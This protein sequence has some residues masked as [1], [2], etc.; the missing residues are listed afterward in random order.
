M[1]KKALK[2]DNIRSNEK[3]L[4]KS[5]QPINLDVVNVDQIVVSDKCK[6]NDDGFKFF[7]GY[8]KGEIIKLLCIILV[9]G[10]MKYFENG[11]KNMS[12]VIKV[13]AVLDKYN[14]ILGQD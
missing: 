4:H 6:H 11:G 14:E 2:F 5:K 7:I 10:Y 3:E 1:S 8:K 12:F 9:T 13:D